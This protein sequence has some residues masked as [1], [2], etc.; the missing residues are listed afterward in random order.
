MTCTS[1]EACWVTRCWALAVPLALL[2]SVGDGYH[3]QLDRAL[4]C[5]KER[6]HLTACRIL[7]VYIYV[8]LIPTQDPGEAARVSYYVDAVFRWR[9]WRVSGRGTGTLRGATTT[10]TDWLTRVN[11][12]SSTVELDASVIV[13]GMVVRAYG[14][15]AWVSIIPIP[16]SDHGFLFDSLCATPTRVRTL[17][18][19][20]VIPMNR[21][22][23][24]TPLF[25]RVCGR[26]NTAPSTA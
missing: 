15:I 21:S 18:L 23:F 8:L 20:F 24:I 2:T 13:V 5:L 7:M 16:Q 25:I 26:L 11:E 12:L 14:K 9:G 19:N 22:A 6:E 4:I 17:Y 3:S 10:V 1:N